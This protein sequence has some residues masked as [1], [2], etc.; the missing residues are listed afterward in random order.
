MSCVSRSLIFLV[1]TW[2]VGLTFPEILANSCI[3]RVA[4]FFS[5]KKKIKGKNKK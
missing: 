3:V 1:K 4:T 5:L 2:I